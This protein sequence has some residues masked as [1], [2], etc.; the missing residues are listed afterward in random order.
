MQ[1][2]RA[3]RA[4][5]VVAGFPLKH[6]EAEQD[7]QRADVRDQQVKEAGAADLGDAVIGG[8][9]EEG[10]ERHRLPRDHEQVRVIGD[11]HARHRGEKS[12]VLEAEQTGRGAFAGAKVPGRKNRDSRRRGAQKEQ[13][14]RG[15]RIEAQME[16]QIGQAQRQHNR[17]RNL[18]HGNQSDGG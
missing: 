2:H 4:E 3:H 12:V 5:A 16:R 15:K 18:A 1:R 11:E 10:R 13:K 14:E 17:L 7:C 9:Q 8:D 6:A